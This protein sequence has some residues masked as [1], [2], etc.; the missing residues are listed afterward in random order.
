MIQRVATVF[1]VG[2]MKLS[3]VKV[4]QAILLQLGHLRLVIL[5]TVARWPNYGPQDSNDPVKTVAA[6]EI[7]GLESGPIPNFII[8]AKF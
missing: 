5:N 4:N 1:K 7:S 2:G 8:A 3:I 6:Y